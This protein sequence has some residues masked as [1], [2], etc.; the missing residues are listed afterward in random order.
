MTP[1]PSRSTL[2][3]WKSIALWSLPPLIALILYWPGLTAWFQRDDFAWLSLRSMVHSWRDLGWA[4]FAPLA[5]G[6]IRTLSERLVYLSFFSA[7][8]MHSLPYR[9][10]AFLT[11]S[12][13]LILLNMVTQKLTGSRAAGFWAAIIW[14]VNGIMAVALAWTAVYYELLCSFSFLLGLWFL[15]RYVETGQRR[16]YVA[17]WVTFLAGFGIL[18]LNVVYPALAAV[19]VLCRARQLLW[20]IAPMFLVSAAYSVVHL[21]VSP[22]SA[23]GPYKMYWDLSVFN[24][25]TVYAIHALGPS[26]LTQLGI[27]HGRTALALPLFFGMMAFL[28]WKLY[29]HEWIVVLFPA[30]FLIV[31][32]PLVPLRDHIT[33]YYLTIPLIGISIWAG[34]A[35]VSAWNSGPAGRVVGTA[36][37]AIYVCVSIPVGWASVSSYHDVSLRIKTRV[38]GVAALHQGQADKAILL[39]GVDAEMFSAALVHHAFGPLGFQRT[40][41]LPENSLED[42]HEFTIDPAKTRE[43]LAANQAAVYDLGGGQ[44]RDITDEYRRQSQVL[45]KRVS[46]GDDSSANQLGPTWY[47][48]EGGFRWMPMR[49]TVRLRGPATVGEKLYVSGYLPANAVASVMEVKVDGENLRVVKIDKAHPQF[50]FVFDLPASLTGKPVVEVE[51]ELDKAFRPPNDKRDL[52]A[53]FGSFEIY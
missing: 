33:D 34:W 47:P 20:K 44:V 41:L 38:L 23:T 7:F 8:G 51:I 31:M 3:N 49:A 42:A 15:I 26:Q 10:L 9:I 36:L 27:E 13:N 43:L 25:L 30:W 40:Y 17:Q 5:Q 39:K 46:A 37:L 19:Y 45:A 2:E 32:A 53:V 6:T 22:L 29:R 18:E 24:T 28:F 1:P 35:F 16:Y 52:G 4:L 11:H 21:V 14:T 48:I 12:A 50:Q